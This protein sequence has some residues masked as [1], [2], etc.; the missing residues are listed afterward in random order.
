MQIQTKL[1]W[2]YN[3]TCFWVGIPRQS[4]KLRK[5]MWEINSPEI[6]NHDTKMKG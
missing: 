5:L 4:E 2:L 1:V 6:N 3:L